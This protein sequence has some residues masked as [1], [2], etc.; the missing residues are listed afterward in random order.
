MMLRGG[1]LPPLGAFGSIGWCERN[2]S[3]LQLG[4]KVG[5][6]PGAP[7]RGRLVEQR[8][9][10]FVRPGGGECAVTSL[11]L[12]VCFTGLPGQCGRGGA[13]RVWRPRR[14]PTRRA[15]ARN[16]LVRAARSS[17]SPPAPRLEPP[18]LERPEIAGT[19][20]RC[21]HEQSRPDRLRKV[22]DPAS[23]HLAEV[24][25]HRPRIARAREVRVHENPARVGGQRTGFHP[26][27]RCTWQNRGPREAH[28]RPCLDQAVQRR[29]AQRTQP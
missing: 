12:D 25:G 16:A 26:L 14:S 23:D 22:F 18:K 5:C 4:R 11:L 2:G 28:P 9:D 24:L 7:P 20:A 13:P 29:H 6:T 10:L 8:S 21:R 1:E 17:R 3:L 15:G 19:G 27:V